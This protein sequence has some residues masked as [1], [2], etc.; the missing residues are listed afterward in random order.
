MAIGKLKYI[1]KQQNKKQLRLR[2]Q[3][4]FI[5]TV[6]DSQEDSAMFREDLIKE[7]S[8]ANITKRSVDKFLSHSMHHLVKGGFIEKQ[9][10]Y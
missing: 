3:L 2:P 6:I 1:A 4:F 8:K 10:V 7:I 5:W 9:R